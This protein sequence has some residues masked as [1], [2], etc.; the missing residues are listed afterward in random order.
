MTR[1]EKTHREQLEQRPK[2]EKPL[3]V[4][5]RID[6]MADDWL[7]EIDRALEECNDSGGA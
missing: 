6:T 4:R 1:S 7:E 3:E 2:R 5:E